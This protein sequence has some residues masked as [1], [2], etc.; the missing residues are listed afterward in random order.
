[1]SVTR[2][3]PDRGNGKTCADPSRFSWDYRKHRSISQR[4][5]RHGNLRWEIRAHTHED[6]VFGRNWIDKVMNS[7]GGQ[8]GFRHVVI[9]GASSGIGAALAKYYARPSM[10]LS[11]LGRNTSRIAA[12][13]RACQDAGATVQSD[14]GDVTDAI[15]MSRWLEACDDAAPI[16]L[17]I[18]NAGVGGQSAMTTSA[19]ETLA[20]AHAVFSTNVIGVANSILPVLPRL[21]GRRRGHVVL[22]SS[23][24]GYLGM[25]ISP[26]YCASKA[27]VRV[28]GEGLRRSLAPHGV[29]VTVVSPGFVQT[30]MS[31]SIPGQ[32]PFLWDCQRAA[33]HIAA[34]IA[35]AQHEI[36]FPWPM[37]MLSRLAGFL[38]S[39]VLDPILHRIR[40]NRVNA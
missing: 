3:R 35:K 7:S 37:V 40:Q 14:I 5:G 12:I 21:V 9:T 17:L 15:F 25:P 32:L 39:S 30:P 8:A 27:A 34:G 33:R 38:P 18:A 6:W 28:Y 2:E 29:R 26:A 20:A 22:L 13:V 31:E 19:A 16:D 1:M 23:L 11:L 36:A 10:R 24:A 4:N